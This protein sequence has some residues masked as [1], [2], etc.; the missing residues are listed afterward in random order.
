VI[1][2]LLITPVII[3]FVIFAEIV[4]VLLYSKEFLPVVGFLMWAILGTVF[5]AVSFS[6]GYIF[7]AKGD[8]K[9][10]MKTALF[11]NSLLL[12]LNVAGYYYGGL[13]GMGISFLVYYFVHFLLVSIITKKAYNFHFPGKFYGM[14]LSYI[15]FAGLAFGFSQAENLWI[16]YAGLFIVL[17]LS[18]GVSLY[19]LNKKM[20]LKEVIKTWINKRKK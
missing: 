8:A 7:I 16:K 3:L 18:G 10:F 5:K 14:F 9:I 15:T 1:A 4:V 13:S 11:F 6:M 20:D 12:V 19:L 17:F 2:L